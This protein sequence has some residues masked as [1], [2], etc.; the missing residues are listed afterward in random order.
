MS[1]VLEKQTEGK[2][3]S[4]Q[5]ENDV[6]FAT[7]EDG[8]QRIDTAVSCDLQSYLSKTNGIRF[9]PKKVMGCF[10]DQT[11]VFEREGPGGMRHLVF[12]D[13]MF[14]CGAMRIRNVLT[15]EILESLEEFVSLCRETLQLQQAEKRA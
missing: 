11:T 8:L 12:K 1:I 10:T 5:V 4:V 2:T 15:E 6:Y 14:V 13:G 9:I 3:D 7:V